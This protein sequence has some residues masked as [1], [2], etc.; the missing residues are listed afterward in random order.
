M[1]KKFSG[2]VL[3]F[4]LTLFFV[5]EAS[6]DK[7][8]IAKANYCLK[9]N[10]VKCAQENFEK[11]FSLGYSS[12]DERD[13]YVNLLINSPL[14]LDAQEKVLSF[15]QIEVEDA[16]KLKLESFVH[17]LKLEIFGKYPNNFVKQAPYSQKIMRWGSLPITYSIVRENAVEEYYEKEIENAFSEWEKALEHIILFE[18]VDKDSNIV[19]E[20]KA[21]NPANKKYDKFVSAYTTPNV[22]NDKLSNMD[23]LFYTI[24]PFERKI[25]KIQLYNTALHE[26]GH[27][28][29]VMGHSRDTDNV[30]YMSKEVKSSKIETRDVLQEG[31]INT[32]K[33]LYKIKPEITNSKIIV[34]EYLPEIVIGDDDYVSSVKLEEAKSYIKKVPT[35]VAGYIDLAD[36]Y[37]SSKD[38]G[39]AIR[40][41][42]HALQIADSDEILE[43]IYFNLALAYFYDENYE[44]AKMYIDKS[45]RYE[46]AVNKKFLLAEIYSKMGK[47]DL[48]EKEYRH[49]IAQDSNNQEYII[50]LTNL[51]ISEKKNLKARA[52]LKEYFKN[53]PQEKKN[54]RFNPYGILKFGL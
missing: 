44:L 20:L 46:N 5:F 9:K 31:D 2:I 15:L 19:I 43:I 12:F 27:A 23:I 8:Y 6:K 53:N 29:G 38:Y 39:Q 30:M 10:E 7:F 42:E 17:D 1:W 16:A 34:G 24:D 40:A 4:F 3:I 28:L 52:V 18:K 51:Y 35:V 32:I 33:L 25:S 21:N 13:K 22:F 54:P 48:A 50:A 37:V 14:T 49:L 26:I 41:L 36:S 45:I 47:V 11:A